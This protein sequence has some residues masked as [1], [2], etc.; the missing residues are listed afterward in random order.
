MTLHYLPFFSLNDNQVIEIFKEGGTGV[1]YDDMIFDP[2]ETSDQYCGDDIPDTYGNAG[3]LN[4]CDQSKYLHVDEYTGLLSTSVE[5]TINILSYNNRNVPA[6]L[7]D[8]LIEFELL[9]RQTTVVAFSETRLS[10]GIVSLYAIPNFTCFYNSRNTAGGH[11]HIYLKRIYSLCDRRV[12]SECPLSR[13]FN[14]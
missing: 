11:C 12:Y 6:N 13:D 4:S 10:Q 2:C 1:N 3:R 14:Y 7:A 5:D 8:F 9:F